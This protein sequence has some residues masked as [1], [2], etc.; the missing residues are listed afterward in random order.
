M[1]EPAASIHWRRSS[2]VAWVADADRTVVLD[3]ESDAPEPTALTGTGAAIW[4][5]LGA[6][7]ISLTTIVESLAA[8]YAVAPEAIRADVEAFLLALQAKGFADSSETD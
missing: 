5:H 3:V 4:T 8:E 2:H 7:P 1:T 6:D